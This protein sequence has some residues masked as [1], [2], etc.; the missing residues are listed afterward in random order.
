MDAKCIKFYEFGSPKDV[1][2]GEYK[3]ERYPLFAF[4]TT[5]LTK[6]PL[7][8]EGYGNKA[9]FKVTDT[10]DLSRKRD[11]YWFDRFNCIYSL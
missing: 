6:N 10:G 1:L 4:G 11:L 5:I 9:I 2:K 3:T 8:V 7:P